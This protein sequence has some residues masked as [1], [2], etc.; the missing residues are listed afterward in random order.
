[1]AYVNQVIGGAIGEDRCAAWPRPG[2]AGLIL[3]DLTPDEGAP[4]EAAA[5]AAGIALVYLVAPTTPHD[6]RPPSRRAAAASS[7]PSRSSA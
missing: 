5:R 1:M 6:R 7:T 4:F 3:A 2:R